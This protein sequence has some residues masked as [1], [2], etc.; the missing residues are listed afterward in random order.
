MPSDLLAEP[1]RRSAVGRRSGERPPDPPG[2]GRPDAARARAVLDLGAV[3]RLEDGDQQGRGSSVGGTRRSRSVPR[4]MPELRALDTQVSTDLD[5]PRRP[6]PHSRP[7]CCRRCSTTSS[8]CCRPTRRASRSCP[9]GRRTT[10][11]CSPIATRTPTCSRSGQDGP[12]TETAV[13]NVPITER[14]ETFAGDNEM[15]SCAPPRG[16]VL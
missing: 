7:T 9:N 5:G 13:N 15:P 6:R 8:P 14:I 1:D 10:A 16:S 12:F 3:L 2:V 11:S 4:S